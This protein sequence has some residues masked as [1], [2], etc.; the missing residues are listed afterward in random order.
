MNQV[1]KIDWDIIADGTA[2]ALSVD[3]AGNLYGIKEGFFWNQEEWQKDYSP[4]EN[5]I[6]AVRPK[7]PLTPEQVNAI[8]DYYKWQQTVNTKTAPKTYFKT[9]KRV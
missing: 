2:E 6:L 4:E 9:L 1:L 3:A 8:N 7:P 5:R